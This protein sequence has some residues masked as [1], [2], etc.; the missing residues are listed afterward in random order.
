MRV[1]QSFTELVI[2]PALLEVFDNYD[3]LA[4]SLDILIQ[5]RKI[6]NQEQVEQERDQIAKIRQDLQIRKEFNG[7]ST[8]CF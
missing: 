6:N 2:L 4:K 5:T 3:V 1:Q 7:E 8:N